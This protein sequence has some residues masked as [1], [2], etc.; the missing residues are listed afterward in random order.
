MDK[1]TENITSVSAM[2]A[3]ELVLKIICCW[4][5]QAAT[6][7]AAGASNVLF[8]AKMQVIRENSPRSRKKPQVSSSLSYPTLKKRQDII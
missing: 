8:M 2:D 1:F 4:S 3:A 6:E 5:E 7:K